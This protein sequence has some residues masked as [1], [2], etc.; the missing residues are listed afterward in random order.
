MSDTTWET[1]NE[2]GARLYQKGHYVEAEQQLRTALQEAEKFGPQDSRVAVVLNN[3]GSL[4]HNQGKRAEATGYYERALSIR[5][6]HYGPHHPWVAQSLNNL[7]SLYRE[8]GRYAEAE[9]FLQ[10][11]LKIAEALVGPT[12]YR[13]TN[14][15]NNLAA[16]YMSQERYAEAESYFQRSLTIRQQALGPTH[17]AVST[18]LSGLAE[19]AIAQGK[20]AEAEPLFQQALEI[21]EEKLGTDHPAVA[22]ILEKY[23]DLLQ[24]LSREDEAEEMA[25]RAK[26]H[27][28]QTGSAAAG[29]GRALGERI[30]SPWS[31][32]REGNES[33]CPGRDHFVQLDNDPIRVFDKGAADCPFFGLGQDVRRGDKFHPFTLQVFV[34]SVQAFDP[35]PEVGNTNLVHQDRL[36]SRFTLRRRQQGNHRG[37][38]AKAVRSGFLFA[39][40]Q[41]G[42]LHMLVFLLVNPLLIFSLFNSGALLGYLESKQ[43]PIEMHGALKIVGAQCNMGHPAWVHIIP[44]LWLSPA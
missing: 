2:A 9:T 8:L 29:R 24:K 11:A 6:A 36:S 16:V 1:A 22:V 7:A 4:S 42:E 44:P 3:L 34:D 18:S 5:E 21:R 10:R 31:S 15:L 17:P 38:F 19:L 32:P 13:I 27:P 43:I 40:A 20:Y 28:N 37:V 14:C 23:V 35:Y 26:D 30:P 39:V 12:H 41:N 33:L 25:A